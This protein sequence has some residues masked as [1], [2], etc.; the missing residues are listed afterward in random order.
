[1]VIWKIFQPVGVGM[2]VAK[3]K[4]PPLFWAFRPCGRGGNNTIQSGAVKWKENA[5]SNNYRVNLGFAGYSDSD[6][7]EFTSGV[8][9]SL[10]GNAGFPTP[11]VTLVDLGARQTAFENALAAAA[12]GGTQLTAVKNAARAALV[13]ALRKEA[14]YVQ[15]IASQ[16]V[17]LL[18]SS[19]FQANSTARTR[20]PLDTPNIIQIDN[21]MST[22]LVVRLQGVDN[23]RAYEVQVKN[24]TGGWLS[25]GV[26]TQSRGIVVGNLTP[27]NIYSVQARAV[28]GSTGYSDWSDPQ[29]HMA[30]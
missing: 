6:L 11:P 15:S 9:P 25:A 19:G 4:N 8:I 18:L 21:G 5:M 30:M 24:G 27:G 14:A 29:S 13:T 2:A 22:Q 23:A 20:S 17:A 3:Q 28:G 7:N 12:Q 16:D 10:T 1:M 26:F